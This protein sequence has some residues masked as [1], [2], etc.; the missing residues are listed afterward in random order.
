MTQKISIPL[1]KDHH[2]HP[3][4]YAL[5]HDCLNLQETKDKTE[6][7]KMLQSLDK[8]GVSVVLGW[9][10]RFYQFSDSDLRSF[11]PVIIVNVSLHSFIMNASAENLLKEKY[12]TVVANYKETSWFEEHYPGLL[13]FLAN[14]VKP[15]EQK[16]KTFFDYLYEKGVYYAE[17]MHLSG[18]EVYS[19][20]RSS[21]YAERTAFW[22]DPE[23][24]NTLSAETQ[25]NIKG[26]KLFTDGALGSGTAA[27]SQPFKDGRKGTLL[28]SDEELYR[29]MHKIVKLEKA[30]AVHAI[31]DLATSQVVRTVGKLK[32][33]GFTFP[34]IRMEHCQFIDVPTAQKA[35]ALGIIF[36]MQPNFNTDSTVYSDRLLP[37]Y[38][39]QNNPF[40]MLI[41]KAGFV[42]GEDL[43]LGSDG[44]P[45]GAEAALQ[46]ALF[47]PFPQQRL[48]L[49]E[50]TAGYCMPDKSYGQINLEIDENSVKII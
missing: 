6:A 10:S 42:P 14:L 30:S 48:T 26:I 49:D 4:V 37:Q 28:F 43:I 3:S 31:G 20:I 13:I 1:L 12:P 46:T 33:N 47:P 29:I 23:T 45:Q 38:S 39:E 2:N 36:S 32:A 7:K 5:F 40:R 22:T 25:K 35:R 50:F 24:F 11:P 21:P 18:E 41:D 27:L 9:N 16:I 44:M 17:E 19:I 8:E 15:T 34:E